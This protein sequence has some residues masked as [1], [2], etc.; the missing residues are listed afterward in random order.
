MA[1]TAASSNAEC[2]LNISSVRNAETSG[3]KY[4]SMTSLRT[5]VEL[6]YLISLPR[7]LDLLCI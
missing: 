5:L 7:A 6:R 3:R 2:F 4:D 1:A